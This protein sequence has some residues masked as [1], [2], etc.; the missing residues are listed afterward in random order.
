MTAAEETMAQATAAERRKSAAGVALVAVFL[1]IA[2]GL[3]S[4]R[5]PALAD[6]FIYLGGARHFAHTGGLDARYYD[7]SAILRRG[8]PHQ[9]VHAPGYVIL[10]G[11]VMRVLGARYAAAVALNAVAYVASG[12]LVLRLA[13]ALGGT[14]TAARLAALSF[15]LLPV[16][17]AYVYWAM[18]ELTLGLLVLAAIVI[19]VERGETAAGALATAFVLGLAFLVRES[20]LF[21]VPAALLALRGRRQVWAFLGALAL[22]VLALYVP[23]SLH[24]APGGANFWDPTS[25]TAFS[26]QAV[27]AT[28]AGA[29]ATAAKIVAARTLTNGRELAGAG[30]TEQGI[31]AVMAAVA[32]LAARGWSSRS[33]L[34]RRVL[35]GLWAGLACVV[36]L[37]FG[38]YVV[39]QWS[40]H[41]YALFL[42]PPLLAFVVPPAPGRRGR[43]VAGAVACCGLALTVS[44]LQV[45]GAYK[46][47]RQRRQANLTAYVEERGVAPAAGRVVLVNGWLLGWRHEGMEVISSLPATAA[48]L[49][50]LER[51]L[52]FDYLVLPGDSP[53]REEWDRRVRYHRL[54]AGEAD[55]PLLVYARQR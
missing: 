6:E 45:L 12:L 21:A 10:L 49:K 2:C 28:R 17:L 46:T 32:L 40:G 15:L 48:E 5:G 9:D 43:A 22:T 4:Q 54:N 29:W 31:L 41:R 27:Q 25:G 34:A 16:S 47:S 23:L 8:Y 7:A 38:V 13:R 51:A 26:Y 39:A 20:A 36:A 42:M 11:A 52:W 3:F 14:E 33:P 55:A 35:A 50:S 18:A 44:T 53:W 24:R 37:L 30:W 1:V 19:A